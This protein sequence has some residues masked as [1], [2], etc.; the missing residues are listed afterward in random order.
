MTVRTSL[1]W[2]FILTGLLLA[3]GCAK[4]KDHA[5]WSAERFYNEA[6]RALENED[7]KTAINYFETMEARY[8]YGRY[9]EQAQLEIAYAYYKAEEKALA[10][11]AAD[12]FIRLHPTHPH[13]AYAYYLK[14]L[15]YVK[16]EESKV[17]RFFR[18]RGKETYDRDTTSAEN[19]YNA[20]REVVERFPQSPYA[21]N[22]AL[23]MNFLRNS[24]G[25]AEVGVARFYLD[26]GAYVAAVNRCTYVLE[27]Y[28]TTP[29]V[30]DALGLMAI[31]YKAMGMEDL[32]KDS[33][34]VLV[35]N[36]P[37]SQYI[38]QINGT[39]TTKKAK[40]KKKKKQS[41]EIV[42]QY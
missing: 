24:L 29:A 1:W 18:I 19:A 22:A 30:E 20:F 6:K 37:Q 11:E 10:I 25:N 23:R 27:N 34:R 33:A 31:A 40:R 7:Y 5:N 12:R 32:M 35:M 42:V 36:F 26:R 8:P 9:A 41:E 3:G 2:V 17:A 14:A 16:P 4:Y 13:V 39:A 15:V 38:A 28:Q 21:R